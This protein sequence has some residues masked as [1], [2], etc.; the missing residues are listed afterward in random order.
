MAQP[1]SKRNAAERAPDVNLTRR[2]DA[3]SVPAIRHT[4]EAAAAAAGL[5]GELLQRMRLAV[6]EACTNVVLHAYDEHGLVSVDASF[7]DKGVRVVVRDD[8]RGVRARPDS[9]GLGFRTPA[10]R[11]LVRSGRARKRRNRRLRAAHVLPLARDL[12][13]NAESAGQAAA[14]GTATSGRLRQLPRACR[15]WAARRARARRPFQ[16]LRGRTACAVDRPVHRRLRPDC[17]RLAEARPP[18]RKSP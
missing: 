17:L 4:L 16:P 1:E 15:R 9:P 13:R 10:H 7:S 2:A 6:S 18:T 8:G 3:E 5:H 14:D 12:R 11:C